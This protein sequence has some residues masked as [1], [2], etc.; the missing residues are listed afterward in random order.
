MASALGNRSV[1]ISRDLRDDRGVAHYS[2]VVAWYLASRGKSNEAKRLLINCLDYFHGVQAAGNVADCLEDLGALTA[3]TGHAERAICIAGAAAQIRRALAHSRRSP[4]QKR[5]L[6]SWLDPLRELLP[7]SVFSNA[8]IEGEHLSIEGAIAY[9]LGTHGTSQ[10]LLRNARD[11]SD[12]EWLSLT[13]RERQVTLLITQGRTNKSIASALTL[14][15]STVERHVANI[16]GKL[17]LHSRTALA[18]WTLAR[19]YQNRKG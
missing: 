16:L 2:L 19:R 18:G 14:A 6:A 8:W 17:G 11:H 12:A 13:P 7:T 3:R 1:Q 10:V 4:I 9:A 5:R 15:P